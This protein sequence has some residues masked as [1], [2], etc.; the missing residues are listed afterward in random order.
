MTF[1]MWPY[2]RQRTVERMFAW[3]WTI[4]S[5]NMFKIFHFENFIAMTLQVNGPEV[6]MVNLHWL[7]VLVAPQMVVLWGWPLRGNRWLY[8]I[9]SL[10]TAVWHFQLLWNWRCEFWFGFQRT[11]II[12]SAI[13]QD[14]KKKKKK[15]PEFYHQETLLKFMGEK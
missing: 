9:L 1:P 7:W 2:A 6:K 15:K 11:H 13:H 10:E 8:S 5:N 4:I 12:H 14:T 3:K